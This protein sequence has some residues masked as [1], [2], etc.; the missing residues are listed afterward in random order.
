MA[1]T[2]LGGAIGRRRLSLP[3][4]PAGH[5]LV[6]F[7]AAYLVATTLW[8]L[9]RLFAE[10]LR[11]DEGRVLGI[12]LDQWQSRSTG[13]AL[14]N[15]LEASALSTLLSVAM[16]TTFAALVTLSNVRLKSLIV[17]ALLLPLLIPSQITALAWIGLVGP[18]S[19]ILSALGIAP[20][21]GTT[22]PLYSKWG[23]VLVMGIEH[24]GLVFLTVRAALIGL[25]RELVEAGRLAGAGGARLVGGI[26]IPL[27]LPSIIA[28]AALSFVASIGNFGVPAFLGIPGR[29]PMMTTLIYQ[30]LQGFGPS[31]LGEVA[32]LA[33]LLTLIAVAGLALRALASRSFA[34]VVERSGGA[35]EPLDLGRWRLPVELTAWLTMLCVSILPL[36]ALLGTALIPATGVPLYSETITLSNFAFVLTEYASAQRAFVN[37]LLLALSA[38]TISAAVALCLAYLGVFAK[39]RVARAL[40]LI[41]DAPYAIPGTVLGIAIILVY[42]PPLPMLDVS[43]YNSFWII[44]IA[45]LARFLILALRPAVGALEALDPALDEAG[46]MAGAGV[47]RRLIAIIVPAGAPALGAGAILI[48]MQAFNEL[49][50]SALLWSSGWETLGVVIFFLQREGNSVAAAALAVLTLS[51]TLLIALSATVLSRFLPKGV[52]PWHG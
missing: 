40:D 46:R 50:V 36:F 10:A 43:I 26:L 4:I 35:M 23:I 8:P 28:G 25:P 2:T 22:S 9:L 44:L 47:G 20:E 14:W 7:V 34:T 17:F 42:L 19:P 16:G 30:R 49:T 18:S 31:A 52:L 6:W 24:A 1:D 45:Y 33:L 15:T 27:A 41:A 29:Y 38:A 39:S 13:R 48:F 3:A 12:L 21:A 32:S 11:S 37:S 5:L 51:V